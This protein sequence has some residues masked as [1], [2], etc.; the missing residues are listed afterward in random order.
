LKIAAVVPVKSFHASKSRLTPFLTHVQRGA[1]SQLMMKYTLGI[2]SKLEFLTKIIVVSHDELVRKI[3]DTFS[4]DFV[5]ETEIGVNSAV[6]SGDRFCLKNGIQS[7]II[8]PTDLCFLTEDEIRLIYYESIKFRSA[9]AI[10][11]SIR[12]DGTNFLLRNPLPLFE[13]SYDNNS[14]YNHLSSANS[15]GAHII[16]IESERLGRDIDTTQDIMDAIN[17]EPR[18]KMTKVFQKILIQRIALTSCPDYP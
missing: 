2:L 13:T 18:N 10:C 5:C 9:V 4:V 14:Y 6:N 8:I 17:L 11:P 16:T 7:N 12:R 3:A 1:V 15:S